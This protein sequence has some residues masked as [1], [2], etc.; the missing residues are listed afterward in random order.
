MDILQDLIKSLEKEELKSYKLYTKRTHNFD[1]R[2]DIELFDS[3]KK[4]GEE[5]DKYHFNVVYKGLKP[6]TKYYRLKN[7]I[8]DDV[9]IVLSNLNHKKPDTDT[10]HLIGLA[11]VFIRKQQY[12]LAL[13]YFKLAEKRAIEKEEYAMLEAIYEQMVRMSIQNT[14]ESPVKLIEKRNENSQRLRLLQDLENNLAVLSHEVKT[15]QNLTTKKEITTWLNH[16]LKNTIELSY[17]KNSSQL[18]IRIFQNVSRLLLLLKDYTSLESYLKS[19]LHEFENDRLF[20]KQNHEVKLQLLIYLCNASYMLEKHTQAVQYAT[21]LHKATLE[22]NNLLYDKYIFYYYNI[23]V[24]NYS[25][26]NLLKAISTL[27]TAQNEK[28]IKNNPHQYFYVLNNLAI[29]NFDLKKFKQAGK[30]F[31]QMYISQNFKS[32]DVLFTIKLYVF[33]LINRIETQDYEQCDKQLGQ[34]YRLI[35]EVK[36]RETIII[37]LAILDI[38]NQYL[39][40][41][42]K[43]WRPLKPVIQLFVKKFHSAKEGAGLINYSHW[44]ES[45]L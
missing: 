2:K 1:Y 18:R 10:I 11:K 35:D 37:D 12:H 3:I 8:A 34:L 20:T 26:T 28:Q 9:G 27:E 30:F 31:S 16:T 32:L 4:K 33:E 41:H 38:I 44:I 13:H 36:E 43:R 25:K 19:C 15:T 17:V 5:S 14:Q 23:L 42:E 6:D 40:K 24:N 39:N 21:V 45:K 7:K 22:F 29:L